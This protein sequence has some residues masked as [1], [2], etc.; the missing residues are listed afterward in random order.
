MNTRPETDSEDTADLLAALA[1]ITLST[2]ALKF[3]AIRDQTGY[4][5]PAFERAVDCI[6]DASDI[7]NAYSQSKYPSTTH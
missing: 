3:F 1:N 7:L 4:P 2:L 5:D 6:I